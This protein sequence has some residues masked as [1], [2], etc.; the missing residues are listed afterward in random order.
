LAGAVW[1]GVEDAGLPLVDCAATPLDQ[2]IAAPSLVVLTRAD[3]G[4]TVM[5]A[6]EGG[7]PLA[8][9]IAG[10]VRPL[11]VV[12]SRAEPD[13]QAVIDGER[14]VLS[15]SKEVVLRCGEASITLS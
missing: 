3:I 14:L 15:A 7:D 1:A 12:E 8:P 11:A 5:I 9:V 4:K 2:P 13:T 6:F 10:L